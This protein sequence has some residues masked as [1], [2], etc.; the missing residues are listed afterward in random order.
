MCVEIQI[1]SEHSPRVGNKTSSL[2]GYGHLFAECWLLLSGL[3]SA[4]NQ[5]DTVRK[6]QR[7]AFLIHFLPGVYKM[8]CFVGNLLG[9]FLIGAWDVRKQTS[10]CLL[11]EWQQTFR[12]QALHSGRI[13]IQWGL[14]EGCFWPARCSPAL[15]LI[16]GLL[17]S[18]PW[19][20]A[21][22][23]WLVSLLLPCLARV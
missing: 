16:C 2:C 14:R 9:L 1:I 6:K 18:P 21:P 5:C 4:L 22:V 7:Y 12:F 19:C 20:P 10:G 11:S 8:W 13:H 23:A 3:L 17:P 15:A